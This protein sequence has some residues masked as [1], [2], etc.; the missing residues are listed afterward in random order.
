MAKVGH[1]P[2]FGAFVSRAEQ[3]DGESVCRC[4]SDRS[5]WVLNVRV[6]ESEGDKKSVLNSATGG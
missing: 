3:L 5:R 4:G 6:R 2:L 1:V